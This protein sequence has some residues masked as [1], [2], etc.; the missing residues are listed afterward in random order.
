MEE[1]NKKAGKSST[2]VI[3]VCVILALLGI[4]FGVYELITKNNDK[5]INIAE[6]AETEEDIKNIFFKGAELKENTNAEIMLNAGN[7]IL[8]MLTNECDAEKC[9]FNY[10]YRASYLDDWKYITSAS[11]EPACSAFN[12]DAKKAFTGWAC[13]DEEYDS[14]FSL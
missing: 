14:I 13:Y 2:A 12:E 6:K 4:G 3:V 7:D 9:T 1:N 5:V 11:N 10:Y 8:A